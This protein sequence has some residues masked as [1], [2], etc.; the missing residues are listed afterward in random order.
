[1]VILIT[2]LYCAALPVTSLSIRGAPETLSWSWAARRRCWPARRRN[3]TSRYGAAMRLAG[4]ARRRC[5]PT[6]RGGEAGRH[7]TAVR[8]ADMAQQWGWPTWHSSEAGRHGAAVRLQGCH[9]AENY[10]WNLANKG[11]IFGFENKIT[12]IWPLHSLFIFGWWTR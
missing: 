1:M 12:R 3:K 11:K 9:G 8:L 4:K 6:W 2:T 7:G 5:W 10:N